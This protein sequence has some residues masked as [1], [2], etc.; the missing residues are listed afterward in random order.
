ML[1][2]E[3]GFLEARQQITWSLSPCKQ[4]IVRNQMR[5]EGQGEKRN[6]K[7]RSRRSLDRAGSP[8]WN[9]ASARHWSR[10]RYIWYVQ[11]RQCLLSQ[12]V[13]GKGI[14]MP[15][16]LATK[17]FGYCV[18]RAV[19]VNGGHKMQRRTRYDMGTYSCNPQWPGLCR[20][21]RS[22]R[23]KLKRGVRHRSILFAASPPRTLER[24]EAQ[25]VKVTQSDI[26][27]F[28]PSNAQSDLQRA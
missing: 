23:G 17:G 2:V 10:E 20:G 6:V 8:F 28:Q 25:Q 9:A 13:C 16:T 18:W 19:D 4:G 21:R 24:A 5:H 27:A 14:I 22:D 3:D 11:M 26:H 1:R 12:G 15:R 7:P